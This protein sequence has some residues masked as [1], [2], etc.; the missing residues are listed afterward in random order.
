[1]SA[2]LSLRNP[3]RRMALR[4]ASSSATF[5]RSPFVRRGRFSAGLAFEREDGR[6][7]RT[8]VL[9]ALIVEEWRG[10][11][12]F[13]REKMPEETPRFNARVSLRMMCGFLDRRG[14][15]LLPAASGSRRCCARGWSE[16]G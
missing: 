15:K 12:A 2:I 13:G 3:M 4:A 6:R 7:A 10:A 8:E 1:M 14:Q 11:V 5:E 9:D 16:G